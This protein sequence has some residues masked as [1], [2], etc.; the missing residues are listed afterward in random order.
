[1]SSQLFQPF[2]KTEGKNPSLARIWK[3]KQ[4]KK[5]IKLFKA[6]AHDSTMIVKT[7]YFSY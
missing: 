4:T 5:P 6:L 1:M 2:P 3:T 7:L